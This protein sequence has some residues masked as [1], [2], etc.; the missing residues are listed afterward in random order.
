[1][2]NDTLTWNMVETIDRGDTLEATF[3]DG[4]TT[5]VTVTVEKG[6]NGRVTNISMND[7]GGI[8]AK[9]FHQVPL[10]SLALRSSTGYT[11]DIVDEVSDEV[12]EAWP[13]NPQLACEWVSKVYVSALSRGLPPVNAVMEVF[14]KT[15]P[16]ANRMTAKARE[17]GYT[18]PKYYGGHSNRTSRVQ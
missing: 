12:R 9:D 7:S 6:S 4:E 11:P 2:S 1:M 13:K 16:T 15:R 5:R 3:S 18:I 10:G 17:L 14:G 8:S